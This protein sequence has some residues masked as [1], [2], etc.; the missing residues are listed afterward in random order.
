MRTLKYTIHLEVDGVE[1]FR[2][3]S[4]DN[5]H[6]V[7]PIPSE[8]AP[9]KVPSSFIESFTRCKEVLHFVP[10]CP[11]T[12]CTRFPGRESPPRQS[13]A[14][15]IALVLTVA[16]TRFDHFVLSFTLSPHWKR[17]LISI[18][19]PAALLP[20]FRFA[21]WEPQSLSRRACHRLG[22]VPLPSYLPTPVP[23][24][25]S[26]YLCQES[27]RY[28]WLAVACAER[29]AIRRMTAMSSCC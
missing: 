14:F 23:L 28:G 10:N 27:L 5:G 12:G 18:P 17:G 22:R 26:A 25:A 19:V 29:T 24:T 9:R 4:R 13:N 8:V 20:V 6:T 16:V 15:Y 11:K 2:P 21:P 7:L 3:I 1:N